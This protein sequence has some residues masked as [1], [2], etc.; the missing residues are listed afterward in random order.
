MPTGNDIEGATGRTAPT[1]VDLGPLPGYLGYQVRQAQAAVFR[2]FEAITRDTGV[3]PGEFSLLNLVDANPGIN[4][5][6]LV[7]VYR[8]DKSTLSHSI[9]RLIRRDLIQ[10]TRDTDDGRYYG[11]WLTRSGRAVLNQV[12]GRVEAQERRM[13]AALKSGEREKLLRL[14]RKVTHA[15]DR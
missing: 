5:I 15:F 2:N 9:K 6:S 12:T 3:T 4:Q 7:R 14:L 1:T 11:L 8:L 10:R 13:A